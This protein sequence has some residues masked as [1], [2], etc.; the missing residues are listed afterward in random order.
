MRVNR[1]LLAALGFALTLMPS[2]A[3]AD[4]GLPMLVVVWPASALALLPV[5]IVE[6]SFA[7]RPLG[8]TVRRSLAL[9][10]LANAA[11]TIIGIPVA[12]GVLLVPLFAAAVLPR[13]LQ[14][15]VV[16]SYVAWLPPVE[17]TWWIATAMV[18][19]CVPFFFASVFIERWVARR[20]F[21]GSEA[22]RVR[23]W[24]WVAHLWSYGGIAVVLIA[25]TVW[26]YAKG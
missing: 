13:G 22:A 24:S 11:S 6:A 4:V 23:Q 10:A 19:L 25:V 21:P 17:G 2:S 16:P 5:V 18:I 7:R 9:S 15:I 14:F 8:L 26:L 3:W 20:F 12:W 1:R